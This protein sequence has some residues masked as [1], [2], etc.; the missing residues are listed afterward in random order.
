[1][2]I[3]KINGP[4]IIK[5]SLI[6]INGSVELKKKYNKNVVNACIYCFFFVHLNTDIPYAKLY[7]YHFHYKIKA[8][9]AFF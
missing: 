3:K 4:K 5:Y 1:M 7:N 8:F 2:C 6:V 9:R